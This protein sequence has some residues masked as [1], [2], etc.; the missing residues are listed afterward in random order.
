M[1]RWI[2]I[3]VTAPAV[4]IGLLL[5]GTCLVSAWYIHRLQKN[6]ANILS[7]NVASL[8]AAQELEI[9]VRQLR[10]HCFL[11]LLDP[12]PERLT[13]MEADHQHFEEALGAARVSA[14]TPEERDC[15]QAIEVGYQHYR[16]ELAQLR[17]GVAEGKP[18]LEFGRLAD[19]HPVQHVV[20]PC[21]ELLR[22]N[23]QALKDADRES[24]RVGGQAHLV[25]LVV[26]IIAPLSG[27]VSGVGMARGLNRSI[28]RLS[29][30][31][32]DIAQRLDQD[33]VSV[34]LVAEG[35]I[36]GLDQQL[37]HVL[38]SVEDVT[39]RMQR[40]QRDML[41]AEQLAAVGQLAA[42]VAHEVRNPLTAVK[43]LV[44]VALRPRNP[45]PI[46][47]DDLRVIHGEVTR[48]E[49]TVQSFLN[50]ARLPTPRRSDCDLRDVLTQAAGLIQARARQQQVEVLLHSPETPVHGFVDPEQLR[51]VLVNL[52]L[53]ALDAMPLGGRLEMVLDSSSDHGPRLAVLDTGSGIA[54]EMAG[55]LFTP[56]ASSKPTGTGLGLS[57]S[58]RIIEEHRG[59]LTADNRPE[60]GAAFTIQ[61]PRSREAEHPANGQVAAGR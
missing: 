13:P 1:N 21:Q 48:L 8:Q 16:E 12:R 9:R 44:E 2:L 28:C 11:Y 47:Q 31:V 10:F 30:R 41:R 20:E 7:E 52:C 19:S 6:M 38:R 50:F 27:L 26:G 60:G 58:R 51:T 33:V 32:Q 23:Q 56:F 4:L 22:L 59:R 53:N 35:D 45:K 18:M 42:S 29:V 54:P 14:E 49:Q 55:R 37:E 36:Q 61:L 15:V 25:M 34:N 5:C 17:K 46:T 40:Q 57:I 43:M 24:N 39:E 3:P